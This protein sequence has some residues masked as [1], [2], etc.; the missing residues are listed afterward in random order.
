MPEM[1]KIVLARLKA[2]RDAAK[3]SGAPF[4]PAGFQ[5]EEHPDANLLAA[6]A[7]KTLTEKERDQVL[8]HLSQCTDCRDIAAL[9]VPEE[10]EAPE[11]AWV[12]EKRRWSPWLVLRW[13]AL[14]AVLGALTI[15]LVL[16][17]D[18]WNGRRDISREAHTP[19]PPENLSIGPRATPPG[20][21][22]VP[23]PESAPVTAR[24]EARQ[25]ADKMAASANASE[26][27][28]DLPLEEKEERAKAR[29]QVTLM[30]SSRAPAPVV[31]LNMPAAKAEKDE[32]KGGNALTA[33]A[34][35]GPGLPAAPAGEPMAASETAGR[36]SGASQTTQKAIRVSTS[37]VAEARGGA[38]I[39]AA[40]AAPTKSVTP[41]YAP[42]TVSVMAQARTV[43]MK[44]SRKE[45]EFGAGQ[46]AA[47]WSVLP[48][49]KV[50]RSTNGGKTFEQ[51]HIARGIKFGTIATLGND[52]WAGG[53]GGALFHSIDGGATWTRTNISSAGNI[54]TEYITTIL[55]HDPQHL[56][57]ITAFG[58]QWVSEDGGQNWQ[59]QP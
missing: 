31:A 6:F 18:R 32:D 20:P 17:P 42:S 45:A 30:A 47:L 24:M 38:G 23:P 12:A 10:S 41:L 39:S 13:G 53:A 56:T 51:I 1:P 9:A 11:S 43:E 54:V 55:L 2:K 52:V 14:A 59:K 29:E 21:S 27:R 37:S 40:Q 5:G 46:P 4:G 19:V 15:V 26:H 8:I 25:S 44:A 58:S 57:V 16:H 48:D 34:H 33:K 3:P 28:R 35:A 7:E 36:A 50:Q 49:G 22:A